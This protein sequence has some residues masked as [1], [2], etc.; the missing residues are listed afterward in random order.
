MCCFLFSQ[1]SFFFFFYLIFVVV[2]SLT[3]VQLCDPMNCNMPGSPVLTISHSLLK[4]MSIES[5]ML[6][7]HLIPCPLF[8]FCLQSFPA[9][10]SFSISWLYPVIPVNIQ[11]WFDLCFTLSGL[12]E[13]S[14]STWMCIIVKRVKATQTFC[15][16]FLY[17]AALV[18]PSLVVAGHAGTRFCWG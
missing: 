2:Q 1:G 11:G 14:V 6:S 10:G 15:G 13:M 17:T 9:S 7:N 8:S 3:H 5:V 16:R 4:L 18:T 12:P